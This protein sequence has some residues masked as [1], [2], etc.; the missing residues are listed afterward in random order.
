MAT[1]GNSTTKQ[2]PNDDYPYATLGGLGFDIRQT[3]YEYTL[4]VLRPVT[5][6]AS[7]TSPSPATSAEPEIAYSEGW[8][9]DF[10]NINCALFRLNKQISRES[11]DY[12][13]KKNDLRKIYPDTWESFKWDFIIRWRGLAWQMCHQTIAVRFGHIVQNLIS[14]RVLSRA[15]RPKGGKVLGI[16]KSVDLRELFHLMDGSY[17]YNNTTFLGYR[18]AGIDQDILGIVNLKLRV[19]KDVV[20]AIRMA[21]RQEGHILVGDVPSF[22]SEG[23]PDSNVKPSS[24]ARNMITINLPRMM[25]VRLGAKLGFGQ[26]ANTMALRND[27]GDWLRAYKYFILIGG[28]EGIHV[29]YL[30]AN[31]PGPNQL[32]QFYG[33][34]RQ[35]P[36]QLFNNISSLCEKLG[37]EEDSNCAAR[38]ALVEAFRCGILKDLPHSTVKGL[39]ARLVNDPGPNPAAIADL[40]SII[41]HSSHH[42]SIF[43]EAY[44]MI[45]PPQ[46][47][48]YEAEREKGRKEPLAVAPRKKWGLS[49]PDI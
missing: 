4:L 43:K 14:E 42:K 23:S 36:V 27:E 41:R 35:F 12:F 47:N 20:D 22:G 7:S 16:I 46:G 19:A 21:T 49:L 3:I 39:V 11:L 48:S 29:P 6:S 18:T 10:Q 5:I 28:S 45:K 9:L 26:L 38:F 32:R 17:Q 1:A 33:G 37:K 31:F 40:T 34:E 30:M 13:Y 8:I 2:S 24:Q 44:S 15:R 25:S